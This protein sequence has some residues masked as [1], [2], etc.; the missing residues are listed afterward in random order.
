M[1]VGPVP[2]LP[3]V[4]QTPEATSHDVVGYQREVK[5]TPDR[6]RR[7]RRPVPDPKERDTRRPP[8]HHIDFQA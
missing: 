7:R 2:R 8:N 1:S 5:R 4:P 3:A 6:P